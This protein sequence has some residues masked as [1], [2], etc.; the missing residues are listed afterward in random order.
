M[1]YVV[2]AL[3][4]LFGTCTTV[5]QKSEHLLDIMI[6]TQRN[7]HHAKISL[8]YLIRFVSYVVAALVGFLGPYTA[9]AMKF[10]N[11]TDVMI[12][13]QPCPHCAQISL[14]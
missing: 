3:S 12:S 7:T 4:G 5:I 11:L 10:E 6:Q 14:F 1:S 8:S 9:A 2:T 13:L